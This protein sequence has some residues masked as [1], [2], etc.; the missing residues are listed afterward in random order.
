M[1]IRNCLQ[2]SDSN[3]L[4]YTMHTGVIQSNKLLYKTKIFLIPL[5][6]NFFLLKSFMKK[7]LKSELT[8]QLVRHQEAT[9]QLL[10]VQGGF[11]L[12]SSQCLC[13]SLRQTLALH[14]SPAPSFLHIMKTGFAGHQKSVDRT[15]CKP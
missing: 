4:Q 1:K 12:A 10:I 11:T 6:S 8:R 3:K 15:S 2:I 7:T 5:K 13:S 14:T 9:L